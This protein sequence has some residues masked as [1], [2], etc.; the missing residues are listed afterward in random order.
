MAN[1]YM[2]QSATVR[3]GLGRRPLHDARHRRKRGGKTFR[4]LKIQ[5]ANELDCFKQSSYGERVRGTF[6]S[7]RSGLVE[8]TAT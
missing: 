7:V 3:S 8:A 1:G 6:R 2:E 4:R 5:R